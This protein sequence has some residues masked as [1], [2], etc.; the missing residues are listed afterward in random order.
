MARTSNFDVGKVSPIRNIIL[1]NNIKKR[2][3]M[4]Y[5]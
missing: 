3:K 4:G 5:L 1:F 2:G